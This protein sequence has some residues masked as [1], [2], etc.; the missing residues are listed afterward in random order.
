MQSYSNVNPVFNEDILYP[1]FN[2]I[3]GDA[4]DCMNTVDSLGVAVNAVVTSPPYFQKREYGGDSAEIGH[5]VDV[6]DFVSALADVFEAVPLRADGSLWVNL[7]DK[8]T[9]G[10]L[11]MVPEQFA[12]EMIRRG[13]H[14]ADNVVWAKIVDDVDGSTEGGC[15]TEPVK[16]RLNS[17]GWETFYRFVRNPKLAWTDVCAVAIPRAQKDPKDC[18]YLPEGL[19]EVQTATDGRFL[20][21]VWRVKMGQTSRKH[22]A[23][24]PKAL[25][26]RPIA[27]TCPMR[28]GAN[29]GDPRSRIYEMVE[30]EEPRDGPR[31]FGKYNSV[32]GESP[33]SIKQ[34]T[35]RMDSARQ[36]VPRKPHTIGWTDTDIKY[37]PGVVLDPF[38]GTGTVGEA[39]ILMGRSFI[40][41]DLYSKF[42]AESQK[43]CQEAMDFLTMQQ[44]DTWELQQ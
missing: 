29:N 26:E 17:N 39:A 7:G 13:W 6:A 24:F 22:Y 33:D 27:M 42:V 8:R 12:L 36:Y 43:R 4:L 34:K 5:E 9:N 16:V 20:H 40:G 10:A 28:V 32:E 14:L 19:M 2:I 30:Y 15:M 41:I 44:I 35:G 18:R 37:R 1:A 11:Q 31:I 38:C 23:V 25:A 3:Q 21:N